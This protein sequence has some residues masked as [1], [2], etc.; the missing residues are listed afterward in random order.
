M[1][2]AARLQACTLLS[3]EA[4]MKNDVVNGLII[5]GVIGGWLGY[6]VGVWRAAIR[7][8]RS[9]YRTQRNLRR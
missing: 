4:N 8:A 2:D 1:I 9:T 7:A 3:S 6:N 5:G